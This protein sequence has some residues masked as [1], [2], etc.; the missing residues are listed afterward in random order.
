MTVHETNINRIPQLCNPLQEGSRHLTIKEK[1][2]ICRLVL[3]M[4]K[5]PSFLNACSSLS[6]FF[7]PFPWHLLLLPYENQFSEKEMSHSLK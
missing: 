7:S 3:K 6:I 4:N 1:K 5:P 2:K